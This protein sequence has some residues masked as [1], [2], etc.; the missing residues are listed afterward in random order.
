MLVAV[1]EPRVTAVMLTP[2]PAN[3]N[4]AFTIAVSVTEVEVIMYKVSAISGAAISGQSIT[5]VISKEVSS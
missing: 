4:S 1:Y 5:L 3:I 2:N